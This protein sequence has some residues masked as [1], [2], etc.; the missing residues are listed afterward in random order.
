[1][2]KVSFLALAAVVSTAGAAAAVPVTVEPVRAAVGETITVSGPA[3]ADVSLE[4]RGQAAAPVALGFVADR[5]GLDVALWLLLAG[6]LILLAGL[7]HVR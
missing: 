5:Y 6:P 3:G 2:K 4:P 1:M 7:R